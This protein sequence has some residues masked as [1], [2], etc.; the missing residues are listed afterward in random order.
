[1]VDDD[2]AFARKVPIILG[3]PT[4]HCVINCMKESE[5]E[6]APPEWEKVRLGYEVH[7]RLYS[8]C[9]NLEPD[10]LFP[11]NTGQDQTR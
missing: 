8:H 7:N 6:K 2:S 10:E 11:T 4:L 9:A 1:M 3:T 5:M